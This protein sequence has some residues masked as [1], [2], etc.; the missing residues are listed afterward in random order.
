[1]RNV[2][3]KL[4]RGLKITAPPAGYESGVGSKDSRRVPDI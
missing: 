2:L 4:R 3:G 1:L